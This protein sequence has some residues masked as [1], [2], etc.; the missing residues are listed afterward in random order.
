MDRK[1]LKPAHN[2]IFPTDSDLNAVWIRAK[3][4]LP[5]KDENELFAILEIHKNT[6]L[7]SLGENK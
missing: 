6:L 4:L 7:K 2:P 5:I 3:S 1:T